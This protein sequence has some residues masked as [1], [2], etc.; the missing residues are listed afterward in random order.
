MNFLTIF[1]NQIEKQKKQVE[2]EHHKYHPI[3]HISLYFAEKPSE[4]NEY[5]RTILENK[6]NNNLFHYIENTFLF[7]NQV[8]DKSFFISLKDQ[9]IDNIIDNKESILSLYQSKPIELILAS[10]FHYIQQNINQDVLLNIIKVIIE[11]NN[12]VEFLTKFS[13]VSDYDMHYFVISF[14]EFKNQ[15][16]NL[17][18]N[19]PTTFFKNIYT[20]FLNFN[21]NTIPKSLFTD[22][23]YVYLNNKMYESTKLFADKFSNNFVDIRIKDSLDLITKDNINNDYYEKFIQLSF[24]DFNYSNHL[25]F[26]SENLTEDFF[27]LNKKNNSFLFFTQKEKNF[28]FK[29]STD[30]Q[31]KNNLHIIYKNIILKKINSNKTLDSQEIK[32]LMQ[33]YCIS[34]NLFSKEEQIFILNYLN[35]CSSFQDIIKQKNNLNIVFLFFSFYNNCNYFEYILENNYEI[36]NEIINV[37]YELLNQKVYKILNKYSDLKSF[38]LIFKNILEY[39]TFKYINN[40]YIEYSIAELRLN[41]IL[42]ENAQKIINIDI[43]LFQSLIDD[44][45]KIIFEEIYTQKMISNF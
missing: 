20:Y 32:L 13:F 22:L 28:T 45:N 40:P 44:K 6:H 4:Y 19:T 14:I 35:S 43:D 8:Y 11:N 9:F 34:N 10:Y 17:H 38:T 33:I 26:I 29:F 7:K 36:I 27:N 24:F 42:E 12:P 30:I 39:F 3:S 23:F 31:L 18:K 21:K 2:I 25:S 15:E 16:M 5:L 41:Q 1:N 37:N